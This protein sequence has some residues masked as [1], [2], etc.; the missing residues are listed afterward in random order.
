MKRLLLTGISGF[1]GR[2]MVQHPQTD[3]QMV[4]TYWNTA[5][6]W[7]GVETVRLNMEDTQAIKAYLDQQPVEAIIH[8]A[9]AANP[10]RC[11]QEP[12]RSHQ[13]NVEASRV[14]ATWAAARG[15]PLVF[16]STD[17]VFD[18]EN[19]PY[20]EAAAARP[21]NQYGKHKLE[22]EQAILA[23]HPTATI[24][25]L[26]LLYGWEEGERTYLGSIVESL[27]SGGEVKAFGD[28]YRTMASGRAAAAGLF[29]LLEAGLR[30][31]WHLGGAERLSRYDFAQLA[32]EV[33]E[34]PAAGI[35]HISQR[36]LSMPAARP[37]DVSLDSRKAYTQGYQPGTVREELQRIY[38]KYKL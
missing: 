1:L 38:R 37:A 29:M 26:P 2:R 20:D 8:M 36:D 13:I 32:A 24:A 22:A 4:G 27:R 23:V 5:V 12:Q 25:R 7:P 14:L 9:A 21:V 10:N 16:T 15:C 30:G 31:R 3:W 34:V 17:L 11:E 35:Q 18:G 33:F 6:N 19:G 28:E